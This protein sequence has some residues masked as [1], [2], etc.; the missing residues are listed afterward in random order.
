MQSLIMPSNQMPGVERFDCGLGRHYWT[1]F[2]LSSS[3]QPASLAYLYAFAQIAWA[4]TKLL[5]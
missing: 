2:E 1:L 3:T 5:E 4:I